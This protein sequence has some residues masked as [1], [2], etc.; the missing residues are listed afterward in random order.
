MSIVK[1]F[2]MFNLAVKDMPKATNFYADLLG[3]EVSQDYRQDDANWWVTVVMPQGG[4]SI[5]L[6]TFEGHMKPGTAQ[7]YMT[8]DGSIED[9]HK[10]LKEKDAK[11]PE[12]KNDLYGP[13]TN[14][15]FI[16]LTDPDGNHVLLVE[17]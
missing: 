10:A 16:E 3:L 4:V 12:I 14:V 9:A 13:G 6:S 17:E 1:K 15:K 8:I 5:T 11:T 7:I 2:M